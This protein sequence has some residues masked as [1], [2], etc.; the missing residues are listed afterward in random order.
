M[1]STV[2]CNLTHS[3][4]RK[5]KFTCNSFHHPSRHIH[6]SPSHRPTPPYLHT[7]IHT[8]PLNSHSTQK[9]PQTHMVV[10]VPYM[11][12][13]QHLSQ[14]PRGAHRWGLCVPPP[15]GPSLPGEE[16]KP[17]PKKIISHAPRSA[18]APFPG[19]TLGSSAQFY[20]RRSLHSAKG[21][22]DGFFLGGGG[23]S[24]SA[25]PLL[26]CSLLVRAFYPFFLLRAK[27]ET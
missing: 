21:G 11:S 25:V 16:A 2:N 12:Y 14:V 19:F 17:K 22:S 13:T 23:F 1:D 26:P 3:L 18:Q 7:S 15:P 24:A 20:L 10:A 4:N 27:I 5:R 6:L 8:Y 9:N